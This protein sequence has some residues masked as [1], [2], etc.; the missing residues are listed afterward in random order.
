MKERV[1]FD[2]LEQAQTYK[3]RDD[4][5]YLATLP[6]NIRQL[7]D[8]WASIEKRLDGRYSYVALNGANYQGLEMIDYI[9][10]DYIENAME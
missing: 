5:D 7:T 8:E 6:Q 4:N 9:E 10:S 2:T 3:T 1:I